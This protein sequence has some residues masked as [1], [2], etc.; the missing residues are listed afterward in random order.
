MVKAT[1]IESIVIGL[2]V[3][4]KGANEKLKK[5][6]GA[7]SAMLSRTFAGGAT[8]AFAT[9]TAGA[10]GAVAALGAAMALTVGASSKFEDSFAGIKK[11]VNASE[12][13]FDQLAVA[14]RTL[15]TEI[16]IATSQL[17]QIGELGGQLG[18]QT[19]G[20][21]IFIDTIAKLGVATRL[22]TETAALSLARL[23][24][25]F[26]LPE[27]EI[28]NLASSLVDLG[29]NFAAL[30]D[31]I[32]STSLRLAAG[33]KVAGATVA[34]T[35]AIA[36]ALQAVGVQSQ[37]G[38]TAMARVFQAITIAL[39]GGQ[40]EMAVFAEITGLG[41]D[42]FR[43]LATE[44][45][46][47]ALNVFLR[48]LSGASDAGRNL[49]DILEDLGLKQQ[50]TIRALLAVSE[51]GD[52][53]TETLTTANVAY[54]LNIA[55]Q[56]EAD[57][58]FETAKSQ[59]KLMK[60]AF[61]ELRI[62]IGN[63]FLPALKN[64]LA[65]LT[66]TADAMT[67]NEKSA[68]GLSNSLKGF[69]AIV[70]ILTMAFTALAGQLVRIKALATIA[71]QPFGQ[72]RVVMASLTKGMAGYTLATNLAA[73][74]TQFLML[75]LTPIIG[76]LTLVTVGFIAYQGAQV[77]AKRQVEAF[78]KAEAVRIATVTKLESAQRRLNDAIA[79]A[80]NEGINPDDSPAV[81]IAQKQVE[82]TAETLDNLEKIANMRFLNIESFSEDLT[83][84][85]ADKIVKDFDKIINS[86]K[87]LSKL[88]QQEAEESLT[89]APAGSTDI[90]VDFAERFNISV[91]DAEKIFQGGFNKIKEFL[92]LAAMADED[93]LKDG[94]KLLTEY[95]MNIT[96]FASRA[97]LG[98]TSLT[99]EQEIFVESQK[100][101]A[102]NMVETS[103]RTFGAGKQNEEM[104]ASARNMLDEYNVIAEE[105]ADLEFIP[106]EVF[107]AM[108]EKAIHVFNV[109]HGA[110]DKTNDKI[111]EVKQSTTD[112]EQAFQQAAK[113]VK[114]FRVE[115][116]DIE[117]PK[118]VDIEDLKAGIQMTKDLETVLGSG[119]V[120]ILEA[121][122]PALA[123]DIARG[124]IE[125]ENLGQMIAIIQNGIDDTDGSITAMNNG[126]IAKD[127]EIQA[128]VDQY[129]NGKQDVVDFLHKQFDLSVD[130]NDI[131]EN[132]E[133]VQ[134]VFNTMQKESKGE[135]ADY[136]A[137]TKEVL[138]SERSIKD[139]KQEII[140]LEEEL[141]A[142][143]EDLVFDNITIT[144]AKRDEV[145]IAEAL[146]EVNRAITDFGKEGVTT[147]QEKL[148]ILQMELNLQKM[149]EKIENKRSKRQEKSLRDKKKEV[150]FLKLA[151]EQGVV[152]QL[153]LDAAQE[154]LDEMLTPMSKAEKDILTL[155][156][157]I[158]AAELE[159]AKA[160]KEGLDPSVISAIENYN[161]ALDV[162]K[163]REEEIAD[164]TEE[165]TRKTEDLQIEQAEVAER[166]D[167]ILEKYPDFKEKS[168]EIAEM[169]GIP[170]Q[171]MQASLD[172]MGK[173]IDAFVEY[174]DFAK[175]YRDQALSFG[176]D[177]SM[178]DTSTDRQSYKD[179]KYLSDRE[180]DKKARERALAGTL[181]TYSP[182]SITPV[183]E[184]QSDKGF[185]E[186]IIDNFI[187]GFGIE[188]FIPFYSGRA[189]GGNVPVGR[190][191]VVG[192]MGPETI[193][194]TPGGTSVFANKTGAGGSGVNIQN[195]N[196]NITGLPADPITARKV[197]Q[198][199][200]RE[201]LKLEK[202]GQAGT[203]LVNR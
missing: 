91:D 174:V 61:T 7:T 154:E 89:F 23:Q 72:M 84:E 60:N 64:L 57:K 122:F 31:E 45:P 106:P 121:G 195:V 41:V 14:V 166:Y 34:D 183:S 104:I 193:M 67:D 161:K 68:D 74:A 111:G 16:P 12:S 203:G 150:E 200:Q 158:A 63:F 81:Q 88:L 51:A 119:V 97:G 9:V 98:F 92:N 43:D 198:N 194:S 137:L 69:V 178:M 58:R 18:V 52:L 42:G 105:S 8:A 77:K 78:T 140:D 21:P 22:S 141:A 82:L 44:N 35:L 114:D 56:E 55:L 163:D 168:M 96:A 85:E 101:L 115:I 155:Q 192:E 196:L 138:H 6:L 125:A 177:A 139:A 76:L 113:A 71:G 128:L 40:K 164:A 151:V 53:L 112:L 75:H 145:T 135:Q 32:L 189:Y 132:R 5:E 175:A 2:N 127:S 62:E 153:D 173:S 186:G 79:A 19:S 94:G 110:I 176:G 182:P 156:K 134:R 39:Q 172:G 116:D 30:E 70:S 90:I 169:I 167:E 99:K 83:M 15:A 17:N 184:Q 202:E 136:L 147:N 59:A 29:N 26:Q 65:G 103:K 160:R 185:F 87:E 93:A 47:E 157:E 170:Q 107:E 86:R 148:T 191:S 118:V 54:D 80:E 165:L 4:M 126:I 3:D 13:E 199:I 123:L 24:T 100:S 131:E 133:A 49:V 25:I 36:T 28:D 197:A 179:D 143:T 66:G 48:G 130:I 102:T 73:R 124:G 152:E 38:G 46:A 187:Q 109:V 146:A 144:N 10:V 117:P 129:A 188:S 120:K 159:V 1:G 108:P 37:A 201:L 181:H 20:L 142:M 171:V 190:A 27:N 95:G 180:E 50:R 149:T 11:T 162:T 33:A